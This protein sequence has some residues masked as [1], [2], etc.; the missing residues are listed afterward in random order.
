MTRAQKI[1]AEIAGMIEVRPATKNGAYKAGRNIKAT[2][3]LNHSLGCAQPSA[4]V[5][6]NNMNNEGA[7]W[8]V[9]AILGDFHKGAGRIILALP[10]APATRRNWGCGSGSKGSYN[11]S[12]VQWEVCEPSGHT[13]AGGTM[14]GYN[15]AKNAEYFARMWALLVKWNV[16]CAVKLGY[17][18]AAIGDHAE[19]CRAGMGSN[20]ADMGHW[21][22]KHG[23]SMDA[24]RAEVRAILE[25]NTDI[26]EKEEEEDMV[27]YEKLKD[28]PE[29]YNFRGIIDGLMTAGVIGGDG[30]DKKG[31]GDV[32]DLSHDMVR[33]FVM[34]SRAGVYDAAYRAAGLDPAMFR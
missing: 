4:D 33:M 10:I 12:R 20:H 32:V 30:S 3:A 16:Y 29:G 1:H 27:R 9:T 34:S 18:A 31:N 28:I 15:V 25:D 2:G 26:T 11:N 6:Y 8:G 23:K 13:Y 14:I 21:L 17:G 24:L 22:P 19:S 7:G 5:V